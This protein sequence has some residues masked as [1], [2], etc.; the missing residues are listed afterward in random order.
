MPERVLVVDDDP[1]LLRLVEA[2]LRARG[3]AV[4]TAAS[5]EAALERLRAGGYAC[6]LLDLMLPGVDGMTVIREA[7]GFCDVPIVVMSALGEEERKV[8]ALD[9]GADDYLVKPF[10]VAELLARVRAAIRR[11]GV[12]GRTEGLRSGP[13]ELDPGGGYALVAGRRVRLTPMEYA[14]LRQFVLARGRTLTHEE[15]LDAVWGRGAGE[16]HYLHVYVG[17]LRRK[18]G[19]SVVIESLPGVGYRLAV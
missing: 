12:Q 19:P 2:N 16:D 11:Y 13:L 3:Y 8:E 4:D 18:L 1:N 5:G 6:V 7:R 14:L 10:G 15:L 9:L 17:R